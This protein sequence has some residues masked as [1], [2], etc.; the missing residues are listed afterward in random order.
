M[1]MGPQ[2]RQ[3]REGKASGPLLLSS[4]WFDAGS[5]KEF[6]QA[7]AGSQELVQAAAGRQLDIGVDTD[8]FSLCN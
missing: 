7:A 6:V 2:R 4:S 1:V 3:H 5:R 8:T